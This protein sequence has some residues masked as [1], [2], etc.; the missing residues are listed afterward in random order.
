MVIIALP[1]KAL[2]SKSIFHIIPYQS[3]IPLLIF[4]LALWTQN[5][6]I[7][8]PK[9]SHCSRLDGTQNG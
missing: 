4:I 3:P 7:I 8:F 5:S 6:S 9:F 2:P 1:E